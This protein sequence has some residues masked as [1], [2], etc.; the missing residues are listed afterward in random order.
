MITL[1]AGAT[2]RGVAGTA[3]AVT[4]TLAGDE[5]ATSDSYKV[6]A[7]GQLPSSAGTLYTAPALTAALIQRIMLANA[8]GTAVTVSLYIN[9]TAAGNLI[10]SLTVPANGSA[11]FTHQGWRVLDSAGIPVTTATVTLTGDVTGTGSSTI[12]TTL[13]T[14]NGNVGS[15]GTASNVGQFTV[16]AKGLTTAAVNVPIQITPSQV[17][18]L[19]FFAT[20]ANLSGDISTTGSGVTTLP[21]VNAGVGS[22]GTATQVGTFTVNAKGQI[23]AASNTA[24]QIAESQV[25]NLVTDLA[26]KQ[27]TGNYL[28]ALTGDGAASGPGSAAFTL[29]T[30]NAGVGSFGTATQVPSITVNAKGLV[31]AAANTAI[32]IAETQ[33]TNLVTDLAGKQ[34]TGNYITALTG[35]VAATGP[36]S[37]AGTL[38]TVNANVGTFGDATHSVTVTADGKGRITA[39][40]ASPISGGGNNFGVVTGNTGTANSDTAGDTIAI[41]GANGV[42]TAA[43]DAPDGLVI[44]GP[45]V[46]VTA[47]GNTGTATAD[48]FNDNLAIVGTG[49]VSTVATD[50]PEVITITNAAATAAAAG[51]LS[52]A[53][54][55]KLS[56]TYDAAADFGFVGDLRQVDDGATTGG[57]GIITSATAA[58]VAGDVGKRITLT[59]AGASAS[60]IYAGTISSLNSGT[61][62]NVTPNTGT[63]VAATGHLR[64]GTD[65]TAAIALMVST[66]NS[67]TLPGGIVIFGNSAT[68][69]WGFPT[70][71]DFTKPCIFQGTGR[72]Y[73]HDQG[74]Y[75]TDG[76]GT[77][78]AWWGVTSDGG[79]AFKPWIGFRPTTT[80]NMHGSGFRDIWLDCRNGDQAQ[81]LFAV[82]MASVNGF[83][84]NSMFIMD[85]LASGIWCDIDATPTEQ[86][87]TARGMISNIGIRQLDLTTPT[88]MTTPILMTS[89]VTLS[90]TP[91]SL[92]VAANT[93]PTSGYMW[94][95]TTV[96]RPA[97]VNYT[98]GGGT[99]T[100]TGCTCSAEDAILSPTTVAGG[101]VV[102]ATPGNGAGAILSGNASANTNLSLFNMWQ[103][104]HAANFWGPAAIECFNSDSMVFDQVVI[105]GG[106]ATNDGAINRIRKPGVRFNGHQT[107]LSLAT[108]NHVFREGDAG[109]GGVSNMA[110]LNTGAK[111][112]APAGPNYW[113]GYQLGNGAPAP[114]IEAGGFLDWSGNGA[115]T[116]PGLRNIGT[117]NQAYTVGAATQIT[118][119][120]I[121]MPPQA[122]QV[123]T[124]FR[125][126]YAAN[127]T[128]VGSTARLHHIRIGTTG[129]V[130]DAIVQT[131]TVGTTAVADDGTIETLF[132]ITTANSASSTGTSVL[133]LSHSAASN[134]GLTNSLFFTGTPTVFTSP[135]SGLWYISLSLTTG[136]GEV[137]Q[138]AICTAEVVRIGNQGA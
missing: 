113:W 107:T 66:I 37:V 102:Q 114:N 60:A 81:A 92:T 134:T 127:K 44:T 98:G 51:N 56:G 94:T 122:I 58:F 100:L 2:L 70:Q 112:T 36:G 61:S 9:G 96:G 76:G 29:S 108:R 40:S 14:V 8:T 72:N 11:Y 77:R 59:K 50:G 106:N 55:K 137:L 26:G 120:V 132:V 53:G 118:G 111:L 35:D 128:A 46:F 20:L 68:N 131:I 115:F 71:C 84:W 126:R 125:W 30:V 23:T 85:A 15:F 1:D 41:T 117:A 25:T 90:T 52:A 39:I 133:R 28:T 69:S 49:S 31:T 34:A 95:A 123:G 54:F 24:I 32:Q 86:E 7:Q 103:I 21:I 83:T 27:A 119:S 105:N 93:L 16:N 104:N 17:T 43:S 38:A 10:V 62:V 45:N 5:K 64:V 33:V 129:T 6:L 48:V 67:S 101:N 65:N 110:L 79:T 3:T 124:T 87:S 89:A 74:N 73:N 135:V 82:K 109:A 99:T 19:T 22:F 80:Q 63:T 57:T 97:L 136:T 12:A 138:T 75:V 121:L 88:P 78:L 91:Q 18:G 13:A 47:T 4:Y 116:L 42:S 130:S